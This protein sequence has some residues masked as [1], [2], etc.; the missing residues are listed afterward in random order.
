MRLKKSSSCFVASVSLFLLVFFTPTAEQS[1]VLRAGGGRT[2][3]Q[4]WLHRGSA[5]GRKIFN[6][7]GGG[8]LLSKWAFFKIS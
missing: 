6:L 8:L 7:S 3:A 5:A 1:A 4:L 2:P